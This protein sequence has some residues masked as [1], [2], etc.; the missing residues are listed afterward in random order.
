MYGSFGDKSNSMEEDRNK[1]IKLVAVNLTASKDDVDGAWDSSESNTDTPMLPFKN[2][3]VHPD[4][5]PSDE[6]SKFQSEDGSVTSGDS[7]IDIKLHQAASEGDIDIVKRIVADYERNGLLESHINRVNKQDFTA[8]QLAARYNRKAVV[9]FLLK[10]GALIDLQGGEDKQTALHLAAKYN[11]TSCFKVLLENKA[12]VKIFDRYGST[13]LHFACRRGNIDICRMILEPNLDAVDA[14]TG[15]NVD[16]V[17]PNVVDNAKAT[18]LHCAMLSDA[19]LALEVVKLLVKHEADVNA[20]DKEGERPIHFAAAED[21]GDLIVELAKGALINVPEEEAEE[22]QRAFVNATTNEHDTALHIAAQA[23]YEE[24]VKTL[25]SIGANV[26]ARTDTHDTPLHLAAIGGQLAV[27]K[28]LVRSKA[29]IN[30][31]DDQQ[32][33]P[34]HKACQYGQL[35]TIKFLKEHGARLDAKDKDNFTPLLCAVWKG[36]NDVIEYLLDNNANLE[37]KDLNDKSV[38]HLAVEENHIST[39]ELLIQRGASGLVGQPDKEEKTPLHYAALIGD[40]RAVKLLL[41]K[42][43]PV[44]TG[45]NEDKTPLHIAAECGKLKCVKLLGDKSAGSVNATDERGKSPLHLAAIQGH[46]Y[47]CEVLIGMGAETSCRDDV[48]W[49]PL[50]YAARNGH[51]KTMQVLLDN[52]APVD[53]C[54]RNMTTPLHHAAMKGHV[55]CINL[56]LDYEASISLENAQEKNCLDL[57]VE[58]NQQDTCMALIKH[59]RWREVLN[60]VDAQGFHPME[61]LIATAPKVAEVVLNNCITTST[62]KGTN[63]VDYFI[64]YDYQF[65]DLSPDQQEGEI[66]FGP[67]NMVHYQREELLS[68]PLTVNLIND[69]WARLGRWLYMLSLSV[70]ILFVSLLTALLVID[71][72]RALTNKYEKNS[73]QEIVPWLTLLL[74][75]IMILKE[76]IQMFY[77]RLQYFKDLANIIEILLYTTAILFMMPFI[78]ESLDAYFNRD[79]R[80]IVGDINKDKDWEY[81]QDIKWNS[82]ALSILLAWGNLLLYLKRFPYFGL[83]VVM[84]VEV[85]KTLLSV[86]LLFSICIIAFALAFFVLMDG[87][88]SFQYVGRSIIKVGVMTIGEFDYDSIFTDNLSDKVKLPYKVVSY[89]IFYLFLIMMPILLMNLLIGL[90]VGDIEAVRKTAYLRILR[91]QVHIL[92]SLEKSYPKSWIRWVYRKD[93]TVYPNGKKW[94]QRF[95]AWIGTYDYESLKDKQM[96][97]GGKE[98]IIRRE[99][100]NNREDLNKQKKRLKV[101]IDLLEDQM[102]TTRRIAEKLEIDD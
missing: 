102:T 33:T 89:L 35:E 64:S 47:V 46:I 28:Y 21:Q 85:L 78:I 56:L 51:V 71:K 100:E 3:S 15:L 1:S 19:N 5:K 24:T 10:K 48:N 31:I 84:F 87:Q 22:K 93:L 9:S 43:A 82:G 16:P 55:D 60:H 52:D 14:A 97:M 77:L 94:Y 69:K 49:T 17:N 40:E 20:T 62:D 99:L 58:A 36:Q 42:S 68:H 50:D 73:F 30:A 59:K 8:L 86:L 67:S 72:E 57:A 39:L 38:L 90:A 65:L 25:I 83:Y 11:M 53:A 7:S 13:A 54:D 98:E 81:L 23:G 75:V 45:D 32:M 26:N 2:N 29:K 41:S 88:D 101:L 91:A 44:D 63:D 27:V 96:E 12:N 66:Y 80:I 37:L 74:A 18:P 4:E 70:Y 79:D 76:L 34:L 6:P 92:R 61:K 95:F